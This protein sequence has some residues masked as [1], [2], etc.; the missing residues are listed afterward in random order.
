M[1]NNN[2]KRKGDVKL[3]LYQTKREN[4]YHSDIGNYKAFG[5]LSLQIND[6]AEEIIEWIPDVFLDKNE[7]ER[8]V[9][10]CNDLNLA[11]IHL[12]DVIEDAIF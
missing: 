2:S 10:V 4:L 3:I 9:K 12:H 11:P 1:Y 5:I 8:F 7:A 6:T